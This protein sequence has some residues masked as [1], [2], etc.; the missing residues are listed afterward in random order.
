MKHLHAK[1]GGSF[2]T[3][4]LEENSCGRARGALNCWEGV[5]SGRGELDSGFPPLNKKYTHMHACLAYI[6]TQRGKEEGGDGDAH[7]IWEEENG[8]ARRFKV[9]LG[10]S[11][12]FFEG[13]KTKR[14]R[15]T[16]GFTP[17]QKEK[18]KGEEKKS[19]PNRRKER[20]SWGCRR[21]GG[22]RSGASG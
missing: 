11:S 3:R 22:G 5:E 17:K 7:Q 6:Q 19:L 4:E 10:C 15:V 8:G 14:G 13:M 1:E 18:G 12:E 9:A 2:L 21:R 20:R 16:M